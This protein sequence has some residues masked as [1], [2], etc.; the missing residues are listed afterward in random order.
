MD[1]EF[2][3]SLNK[4][5]E[6]NMKLP[7]GERFMVM[8]QETSFLSFL[9]SYVEDKLPVNSFIGMN[10][11][12]TKVTPFF[13][14]KNTN[15][16]EAND[17]ERGKMVNNLNK[18]T[19][20]ANTSDREKGKRNKKGFLSFPMLLSD[21]PFESL[22]IS[23]TKNI[24]V[25]EGSKVFNFEVKE[26]TKLWPGA[27]EE[28]GEQDIKKKINQILERYED[29]FLH[30]WY[31]SI[32][33]PSGSIF[34]NTGVEVFV[35]V[36]DP[37]MKGVGNAFYL[38]IVPEVTAKQNNEN[39]PVFLANHYYIPL[40]AVVG[41]VKSLYINDV[42]TQVRT[43]AIKSA[44]AAIM[45]RN[46]SH[47]LGSHY[48]Y[49]TKS[50]LEHLSDQSGYLNPD[51]RGA[52]K[53]ISYIQSRMDYLATIISNDKYPYGSVNFK[54]QIWDELTVDDFSKRHYSNRHSFQVPKKE[55]NDLNTAVRNIKNKAIL[56]EETY[57]DLE[58]NSTTDGIVS[59]P[60]DIRESINAVT[61]Q[62]GGYYSTISK[63][64]VND[65]TTNFLLTNLIL[66]ENYTRPGI[67]DSRMKEGKNSLFLHVALWNGRKFELFTGTDNEDESKGRTMQQ[68]EDIKTRLSRIDLALPGGTMSCHAF[69]NILE[70][71][72]RN[73]A[74]YSWSKR[75]KRSDLVFTVALKE[76][77]HSHTIECTFF[78]NKHDAYK[79]Q[80]NTTL[81]QNLR[82][83][84]SSL[85]IL[86][87]NNTVDKENKGLKE[88]LFSAVWLRA[89][90][91]DESLA[92]IFTKIQMSPSNSKLDLIKRY[93]FEFVSVD[94]KGH[95]CSKSKEANLGIRFT[96]PLFSRSEKLQSDVVSDLL[97]LHTDIVDLSS[98]KE[99]KCTNLDRIYEDLFPRI[100]YH[101][102]AQLRLEG[103]FGFP[104]ADI[105]DVDAGRDVQRL[106]LSAERNL[107]N[108]DDYRLSMSATV[109]P[110]KGRR[111]FKPKQTIFYDTHFS[112]QISKTRLRKEYYGKYAYVDTISGNNF[113]KTLAG[114]FIS[115]VINS[116]GHYCYRNWTDKYLALKIKEAALTRITIIDER[117][118]N[119]VKWSLPQRQSSQ[120][121]IRNSA[122]ELSMKNIRVLNFD[123]TLESLAVYKKAERTVNDSIKN[124][125]L[126]PVDGF[127]CLH[128]N[129]FLHTGPFA[130]CPNGTNFLSIH[131]GLIE[132][133]LKSDLV[134][135]VCGEKGDNPLSEERVHLFMQKLI[136]TFTIVDKDSG[137][138]RPL[139]ICIHSGRGN[140]SNELSG[141]LKEYPFISLAALESAFNNSKY[142]LSQL[143]YNTVYIGKGEVNEPPKD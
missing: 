24:D 67:I 2:I 122:F 127:S 100:C 110:M 82:A 45:S 132:K 36:T 11:Q 49:Y 9:H 118:Y 96:L 107:G 119:G 26:E 21:I 65:R 34:E 128:G 70:N 18:I 98:W 41:I 30:S 43:E 56:L 140:F 84:L 133:I 134:D 137:E 64:G 27:L 44:V 104:V 53:V 75:C 38:I 143:F 29:S 31:D 125:P 116:E 130:D 13:V 8:G 52:A 94:S 48:L 79:K 91:F 138:S 28:N 141:P 23:I 103:I 72:I 86:G 99:K 111:A 62:I 42:N 88:M 40:L 47:N 20:D 106:L 22:N 115:S 105:R 3:N 60:D 14:F 37:D 54:S 114:M 25:K 121:D 123:D 19:S 97:K 74:K 35:K 90:E 87:E 108:L 142:L 57:R 69:F 7:I 126:V 10:V 46:M 93:A 131:L 71:F 76:N 68:E 1:N 55:F 83:R 101:T 139:H 51:I 89:N 113:S 32:L 117:L 112:T 109:E 5:H 129:V 12:T 33:R 77:H 95:L 4:K 81:V 92:D 85:T 17:D 73:S 6:L 59:I 135:Q 124:N 102:P 78:D 39:N 15:G 16:I 50:T 58:V 80:N 120:L 136:D 66:S 63:G 61:A